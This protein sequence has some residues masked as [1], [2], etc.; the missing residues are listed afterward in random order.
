MVREGASKHD[1]AVP[2]GVRPGEE[3][4]VEAQHVHLCVVDE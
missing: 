1:G 3:G 2:R 4:L